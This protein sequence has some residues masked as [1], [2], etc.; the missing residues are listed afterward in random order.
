MSTMSTTHA[1]QLP[2]T[3]AVVVEEASAA[4]GGAVV[5]SSGAAPAKRKRGSAGYSADTPTTAKKPKLDTARAPAGDAAGTSATIKKPEPAPA[6]EPD[7]APAPTVADLAVAM[8]VA[9]QIAAC[10]H[11]WDRDA[12]FRKKMKPALKKFWTPINDPSLMRRLNQS[13]MFVNYKFKVP[14]FKMKDARQI[15]VTRVLPRADALRASILAEP[16]FSSL[17]EQWVHTKN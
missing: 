9:D 8:S 10:A 7:T 11:V 4:T 2:T 15:F 17:L 16:V 13:G 5:K 1:A 3:P 12:A 14:T 6:P